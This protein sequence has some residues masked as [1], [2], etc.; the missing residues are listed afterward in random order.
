[1]RARSHENFPDDGGWRWHRRRSRCELVPR[2]IELF[3]SP[4]SSRLCDTF[5]SF[6][7]IF[8]VALV[9]SPT[10]PWL[11]IHTF[12]FFHFLFYEGL[13]RVA[14]RGGEEEVTTREERG[15]IKQGGSLALRQST[16]P[17]FLCFF[18]IIRTIVHFFYGP[19]IRITYV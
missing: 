5:V 17:R 14:R 16:P 3:S 8:R 1:M 19:T 15:E 11:C 4:T 18:R 2:P 6:V 13:G 10:L 7:R 9:F 12:S